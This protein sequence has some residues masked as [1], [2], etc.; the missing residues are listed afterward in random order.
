MKTGHLVL[1]FCVA[2]VAGFLGE[3]VSDLIAMEGQAQ[4]DQKAGETIRCDSLYAKR[5]IITETPQKKD[6][7]AKMPVAVLIAQKD[8]APVAVIDEE[9]RSVVELYPHSVYVRSP[10]K[11]KGQPDS[12]AILSAKGPYG[13]GTL[14]PSLSLVDG[15]GVIRAQMSL[16]GESGRPF[17]TLG[18]GMKPVEGKATFGRQ[19]SLRLEEEEGA[20]ITLSDSNFVTRA[21]LGIK[22]D[23]V[24]LSLSD[25]N[26]KTRTVIGNI[27][28]VNEKTG[29]VSKHPVSSI[30]LFSEEGNAVWA[31][32]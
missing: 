26:G 23:G 20:S 19:I 25:S 5:V 16:W 21:R 22:E 30:V 7:S 32:P 29:V 10:S 6:A 24:D 12:L 11:E 13:H 18:D 15:E 14:G 27:E 31:A 4:A 9:G 3:K 2:F 17:I 28:L 1:V 8:A